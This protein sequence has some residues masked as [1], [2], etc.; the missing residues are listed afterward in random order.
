MSSAIPFELTFPPLAL[1][2]SN[3]SPFAFELS[4]HHAS[5]MN[6]L[7]KKIAEGMKEK[8]TAKEQEEESVTRRT[9]IQRRVE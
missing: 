8:R 1:S 4:R 2:P 7:K 6:E 3:S 5:D 9:P